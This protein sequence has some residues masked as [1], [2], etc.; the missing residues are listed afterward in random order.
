MLS[1]Q[2]NEES[3]KEVIDW[4]KPSNFIDY[5]DF[6]NEFK[7]IFIIWDTHEKYKKMFKQRLYNSL[8]ENGIII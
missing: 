4:L 3:P 5:P 2:S 1:T 8:I 7:E 6:L